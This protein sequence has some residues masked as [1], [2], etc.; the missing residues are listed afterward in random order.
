MYQRLG[1]QPPK[2]SPNGKKYSGRRKAEERHRA[3]RNSHFGP[4][5]RVVNPLTQT[6]SRARNPWLCLSV[7]LLW[8]ILS[9]LDPTNTAFF[10]R[11]SSSPRLRNQRGLAIQTLLLPHHTCSARGISKGTPTVNVGFVDLSFLVSTETMLY[12]STGSPHK[13]ASGDQKGKHGRRKVLGS[14]MSKKAVVI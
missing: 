1:E 10:S 3:I 5:T 7:A 12:S 11:L 14:N 9:L 4:V 13:I 2:A 8:L 6:A